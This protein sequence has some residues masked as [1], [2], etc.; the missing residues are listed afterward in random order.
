M[1]NPMDGFQMIN[2]KNKPRFRWNLDWGESSGF[3]ALHDPCNDYNIFSTGVSD[4]FEKCKKE[5]LCVQDKI[6][7]HNNEFIARVTV[8]NDL[9][10]EYRFYAKSGD[11]K[12]FNNE[13]IKLQ[14]WLLEK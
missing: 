3:I 7:N 9:L 1:H 13:C 5:A 8:I 4:D 10:Q 6:L 12:S 2:F 14:N 11:F